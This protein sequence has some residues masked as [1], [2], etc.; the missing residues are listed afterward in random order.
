MTS[1]FYIISDS[2]F[3][4]LSQPP[5]DADHL[6]PKSNIAETLYPSYGQLKRHLNK[7]LFLQNQEKGVEA[8]IDNLKDKI[9]KKIKKEKIQLPLNDT[10]SQA[11]YGNYTRSKNDLENHLK[12]VR[13]DTE[14]KVYG[15]SNVGQRS[16]VD[17]NEF[18]KMK[19]KQKIRVLHHLS[20]L[21]SK[22]NDTKWINWRIENHGKQTIILL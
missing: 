15:V 6:A 10:T 17:K 14:N 21:N 18:D 2:P 7:L 4:N 19:L 9:Y 12:L 3:G 5:N 16:F 11:L 1:I 20:K 13:L 8:E 22:L